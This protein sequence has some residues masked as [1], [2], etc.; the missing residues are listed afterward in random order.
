MLSELVQEQSTLQ[1]HMEPF[2]RNLLDFT[3]FMSIFQE[4]V[5]KKID[6][7]RRRLTRLIKYTRG[8]P[9][10]FFKNFINDRAHCGCKNTIVLLQKQY[11]NPHIM[12]SSHRKEI[13]WMQPL[14]PGVAA[15]FQRLFNFLIKCQTVGV[16][17][18]HNPLDTPEMICMIL[19][20]LLWHL[21]ARQN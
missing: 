15:A 5:E 7:P 9:L 10:G 13:K 6:D 18:K 20:K 19:A 3:Y 17:S 12:L 2:E 11:G 4:S 1:V 14:K 8:E 16:G 21:L